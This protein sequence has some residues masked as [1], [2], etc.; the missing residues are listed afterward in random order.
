MDNDDG[1][2]EHGI[3]GP[4]VTLFAVTVAMQAVAWFSMIIRLISRKMTPSG[5]GKDDYILFVAGVSLS[6]NLGGFGFS[7]PKSFWCV[8]YLSNTN[9]LT[10]FFDTVMTGITIAGNRFPLSATKGRLK[11]IETSRGGWLWESQ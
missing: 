1:F 5:L 11:L 3:Y 4:G 9:M 8:S 2:R 10:Q 6:Q 7:I